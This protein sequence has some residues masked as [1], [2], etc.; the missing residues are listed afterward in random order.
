MCPGTRP[1][2]R[3]RS[4]RGGAACE[5]RRIR[6]AT[7]LRAAL[8]LLG[9]L[10]GCA[11]APV[12]PAPVAAAEPAFDA[13]AAFEEFAA[14][15]RSD[16]AYLERDDLDVEAH[17]ART[18]AAAEGAADRAELRRILHRSTFAF[19]DPHLLVAP[20]EDA[21]PN[22]WPTSADLAV[23]LQD[24]AFVVADVRAGSAAD[25]AGVRPGWVVTA[26]GGGSIAGC[27]AGLLAG[28]PA[29]TE[30]QRSY[31]A[32]LCVN[33]TRV[34]PRALEFAVDGQPRALELANPRVFAEQVTNMAPLSVAVRGR[35]GVVRFNNSLGRQDTIAAIDAAVRELAGMEAVVLDLRNTPSGGNTDVARAIL[36]HFVAEPRPYQVHEVPAVLRRTSVPRRFVE[37]VLPRDPLFAGRVVV[38]GGR[39]TGSMGEGVVIGMHAAAGARTFA[40]DMGD[41]LG[42]L[43]VQELPASG[44][45]LELG[46]EAL[47][48][49]DGTPRAA[50]VGDVR[51]AAADRDANGGDP[52][53]EAALA[54][55]AERPGGG[56]A[57]AMDSGA[58]GVP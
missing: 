13:R 29:P 9:L 32:T 22:V 2:S 41:L 6:D 40:S 46:A 51:L 39:W 25:G 44:V 38:L 7:G 18:R 42:A 35:V 47:F 34:G 55:L 30:R 26:V 48:H 33:G 1:R 53:L 21:D 36:G 4:S 10:G 58:A 8:G 17:L 19:A 5:T 20:L 43:H 12:E 52:A 24:G 15:L 57:G 45:T 56:S 11:P 54:W 49:V 37:Y 50:F 23:T 31:A 3:A 16:Y 28:V 14:A 27:S